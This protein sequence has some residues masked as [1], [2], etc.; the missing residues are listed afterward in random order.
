MTEEDLRHDEDAEQSP[1]RIEERES[2]DA[3]KD[4]DDLFDDDSNDDSQKDAPVTREELKRLE[5]GIQNLASQLGRQSKEP[6][7][8]AQIKAVP[9]TG[10]T[11]SVLK[12]LYMQANPEAKEVW[13]DVEREAKLLGKDPFELYEASSYF[14]GEAKARIE[15]KKVEEESRRKIEKPS[16]DTASTKQDLDKIKPEDV[17]KL[18]PSEKLAWMKRQADKERSIID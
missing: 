16:S 18:K 10:T 1:T 9:S 8:T 7:E 13:E 17:E 12:N 11:G 4:L 2:E 14:K 6:K 5:K 15:A 3:S